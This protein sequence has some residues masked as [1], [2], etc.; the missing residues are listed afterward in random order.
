MNEL[1]YYI[2]RQ[3]LKMAVDEK[4]PN[5][6][7]PVKS[8]MMRDGASMSVQ[9]G[10]S[11]YS[12]PAEDFPVYGWSAFEVWCVKGL[13]EEEEFLLNTY[14]GGTVTIDENPAGWVGVDSLMRIIKNHGGIDYGYY[15]EE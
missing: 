15:M 10:S 2:M 6:S 12:T 8:V 3:R 14:C 1:S 4:L 7:R 11:K 9:A 13:T 5:S